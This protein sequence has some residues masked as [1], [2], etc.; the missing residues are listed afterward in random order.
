MYINI[1]YIPYLQDSTSN[2]TIFTNTCPPDLLTVYT[3]LVKQLNLLNSYQVYKEEDNIDV[4]I[5]HL[6]KA[7]KK[8]NNQIING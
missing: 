7:I 1:D 4:A 5:Y 6:K 2:Y 3:E 8:L